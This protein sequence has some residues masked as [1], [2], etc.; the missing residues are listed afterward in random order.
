MNKQTENTP[1]VERPVDRIVRPH[2][3]GHSEGGYRLCLYCGMAEHKKPFQ[4][5]K[6]WFAGAGYVDD[7]GCKKAS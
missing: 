2:H 7:Q 6:Y 3:W 5:Y 4:G 1:E